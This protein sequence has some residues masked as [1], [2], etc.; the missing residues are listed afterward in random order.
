MEAL[1]LVC[2]CFV[3]VCF[4][5]QCASVCLHASVWQDKPDT[6]PLLITVILGLEVVKSSTVQGGNHQRSEF[7][8]FIQSSATSNVKNFH[9]NE[10]SIP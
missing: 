2:V 4:V 10:L 8:S 6:H 5:C 7:F 3:C 9:M 1:G